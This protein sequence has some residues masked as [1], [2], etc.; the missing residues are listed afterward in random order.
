MGDDERVIMFIK[1]EDGRHL[2]TDLVKTIKTKIRNELSPR[3]VPAIVMPIADIPVRFLP[4]RP[5]KRS[6]LTLLKYTINGKKVEVA[7][8]KIIS[9]EAMAPSGQLANPD[10]LKLFQNLPEL[11]LN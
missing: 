8:K 9:G 3:H 11:Q 10:S 1:M 4:P 2:D 7:V 6:W 5:I